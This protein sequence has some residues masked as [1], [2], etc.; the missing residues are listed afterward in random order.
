MHFIVHDRHDEGHDGQH[1]Q[2][3]SDQMFQC[4]PLRAGTDCISA[5]L[6]L[7]L[8]W[9]SHVGAD[10]VALEVI[11]GVEGGC[12]PKKVAEEHEISDTLRNRLVAIRDD[13]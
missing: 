3:V 9:R 2:N 7:R 10:D 11:I 13:L 12:E 6:F 8:G 5:C 4:G 1:Q